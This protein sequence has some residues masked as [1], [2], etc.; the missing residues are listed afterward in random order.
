MKEE[1]QKR[2]FLL[3]S[4]AWRRVMMDGAGERLNKDGQVI[5]R[6]LLKKCDFFGRQYDPINPHETLIKAVK[7]QFVIDILASLNMTEAS[8]DQLAK[9]ATTDD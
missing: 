8:I 5:V 3:V 2:Q 4:R 1:S 9:E 6:S 7:R